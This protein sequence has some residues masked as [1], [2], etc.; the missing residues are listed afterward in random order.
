VDNDTAPAEVQVPLGRSAVRISPVGVGA[1]VW[2]DG[3]GGYYG[4]AAAPGDAGAAFRACL[5]A[6]ITLFDTAEMYSMG[7]AERV[8]GVLGSEGRRA[9]EAGGQPSAAHAV[10]VIATKFA[11]LPWRLSPRS[12]PKALQGSLRRLGVPAID[13]SQMHWAGSPV[14]I[15]RWMDAMADA[16]S[17]GLVRAVGV[18][19]YDAAQMRRAHAALARRGVPLASN[20]VQY[21]LLHRA[22]ERDGVLAACRELGVTPIAYMPLY[23]GILT[24]K[25]TPEHRPR[26][27]FRQFLPHTRPAGLARVQPLIGLLREVGAAH[28]GKTPAQVA[29]NWL[30]AKGAVPISGVRNE[31]QAR[32]LAGVVGWRLADEAVAALDAASARLSAATS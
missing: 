26:G 20:Q 31:G 22:P 24:G 12:L 30:V 25:Y 2:G 23:M 18:S 27:L 32:D 7:R 14:A 4:R 21:S 16:V 13:L 28:G 6:R 1:M 3:W 15:E 9:A 5:D 8:L 19:N 17:E 11:P 29:L 10:P